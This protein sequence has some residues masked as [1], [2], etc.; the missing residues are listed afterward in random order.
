MLT[1]E[2][3]FKLLKES[4]LELKDINETFSISETDELYKFNLDSLDIVELQMIYE[5]KT[6]NQTANPTKTVKTVGDLLDVML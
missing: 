2:E 4:I 6:G 3:K 1:R 5:E